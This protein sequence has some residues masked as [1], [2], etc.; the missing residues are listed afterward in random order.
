MSAGT[1]PELVCM[2]EPMLELNAQP[3]DAA[4]RLLYLEGFGGDTSN[5]AIAAARQGAAVAYATAIG[6]DDAGERFLALWREEGVSVE[7]VKLDAARPTALYLVTHGAAGHS[8]HFYRA[9]SAASAYGPADVPD[10]MIA[11]SR[12]FYASGISQAIS[13]NAA[14]AVLHA[15]AVARHNQ[16]RVAF[17]T[18]YRP[19]LWPRAR[20][21]ALIHAA[22][23]QADILL[24]SIEDA[25][26]LAGTKDADEAADFY[27][28]LG[29]GIVVITLGAE[30][31]LLADGDKRLRIPALPGEVVDATGAG[32]A[33]AGAFLARLLAGDEAEP[34]ARYASVAAGIKVRG[35]GAVAPIPRVAEVE[36]ALARC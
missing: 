12:M 22:A 23:R 14:D 19:R 29:P 32:D 7:A 34:A 2:G 13:D 5:A 18:N 25:T 3:P 4:G 27:R 33:F 8:F 28:Q 30:G 17:G 21:A 6:R 26:A 11:R 20:A 16:V 36:A 31:A 1:H 35:Y 10:A 15:I 24:A 9:G